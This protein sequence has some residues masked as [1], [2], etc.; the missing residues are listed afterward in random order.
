LGKPV[1]LYLM[2]GRPLSINRLTM[3]VQAIIEGWYMGQETGTAAA[4]II[5]GDVNPSGKLTITFPKSAGQIPLYYNHKPS[6]QFM[7]Y[8]SQDINPLFCFGYG[9]SYTRFSC[10]DPVLKKKVI[11]KG[12]TAFVTVEVKNTG[13]VKGD[14]II[15]LYIRDTISSVTRPVKELKDFARITLNPG[16]TRKVVFEITP[17]KLAFHNIAMEYV[18]EPGMFE[19]MTGSSS[20]DEDLKKTYLHVK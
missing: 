20:A 8:I 3:K 7:D 4:E 2:N 18:T 16:E 6:A 12:E 11:S 9:L 1:I 15:Q 13:K 19:I 5:F 17:E 10:S 14:E